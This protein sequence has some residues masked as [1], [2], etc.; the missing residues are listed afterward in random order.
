MFKNNFIRDYNRLTERWIK[1]YAEERK[2]E[3]VV[4]SPFSLISLLSIAAD[5]TEGRTKE[6][7]ET[8]LCE[9][10]S[11]RGF[12]EEL[13]KINDSFG[14]SKELSAANAVI[15]RESL[16]GYHPAAVR[17]AIE[18]ALRWNSFLVRTGCRRCQCLGKRK[19]K[20]DDF[21]NS[22]QVHRRN[23]GCDAQC[24]CL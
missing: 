20:G 12:R 10:M 13:K 18:R 8:Y 5:A 23:A 16:K 7:I 22:R 2:G 19:N 24:H 9:N 6:E 15:V 3:N 4:F 17:T 14:T 11:F 1:E 21:R